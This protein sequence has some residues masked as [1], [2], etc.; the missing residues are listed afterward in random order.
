MLFAAALLLAPGSPRPLCAGTLSTVG[1]GRWVTVAEVFDGDTF[2]TLDGERVR[3]LGINAPEVAHRDAPAQPL[4]DAAGE[5][6]RRRITG[7]VVRL[8]FDRE[9]RDVYGRLLAQ[10][11]TR[12]GTWINGWMVAQ[13]WAHVYTFVPNLRWAAA[14]LRLERRARGA[15]RGIWA[16]PRWR[17]L[18]AGELRPGLLGQFRL[19]RGRVDRVGRRGRDFYLGALHVTVPKKFRDYFHFPLPVQRGDPVVVRGKIRAG[20]RGGWFISLHAPTDLEVAP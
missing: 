3:L 9:R 17:V 16:D 19:V 15:G 6:L 20:V 8:A 12:D 1:S 13:G 10:V 11:Y 2:R 7:R 4:G 14:L 5:A 18:D